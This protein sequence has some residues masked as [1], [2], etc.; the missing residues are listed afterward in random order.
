MS[1]V[2]LASTVLRAIH[3]AA[4]ASLFGTL[5]FTGVVLPPL[6]A[7]AYVP[8]LQ[9]RLAWLCRCSMILALV[10]GGAWLVTRAGAM[11][12]VEEVSALP[13]ALVLVALDTRFGRLLLLRLGL[14]FTVCLALR[15]PR[16]WVAIPL[17]GA[18]L[19]LQAATSHAGAMD[20]QPGQLLMLA[21]ALHI[22][23]AAAWLGALAPLLIVLASLPLEAAAAV[24][25]RFFPLGLA[26]VLAIA[27]TSLVQAVQLV[28]SVAALFGTAYGRMALLKL[29]L[30]GVLLVFAWL[31]RFVFRPGPAM[32]RSIS[33]EATVAA[34]LML[35][36]GSL[37]HMAPGGHEQA[38]WPFPWQLNPGGLSAPGGLFVAATPTTFFVSPTGFSAAA[39]VRGGRVYHAACAACHGA[40]GHGD[41]PAAGTLETVP[42][43]LTALRL[44][45]LSDGELFWRTGHAVSMTA[46][47]R[48]D[49][50]DYLRAHN[51]GEFVRTAGRRLQL[52]R[53]P[54]FGASCAGG[55]VLAEAD[56]RGRV[57]HLVVPDVVQP[58]QG[59]D[60]P[61]AATLV[62]ADAAMQAD[63]R[64][65]N[66]AP[67][68][69]P[70]LAILLGATPEALAG[71]QFLID[72]NGWLRA[73]WRPGE[74]AAWTSPE[75]LTAR[76]RML[77]ERPLPA[78][79]AD[80]HAGHH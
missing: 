15:R 64:A 13:G 56:L 61:L 62:L 3:L 10:A 28:G 20:G 48:W 46:D 1:G 8:R 24:I 39:I 63:G 18:A 80:A 53:I 2:D 35:A 32:R 47:D 19:A 79:P 57:L 38:V 68:A 31:N 52:L 55:R 17:S 69:R 5:V 71:Q 14:L 42:A 7:A 77:A 54:R 21:E 58:I 37:A 4:V 75:L 33:A 76:V 72:P 22:I 36:A 6:P 12:A 65:C 30:F 50:V 44:L 70:A 34:V 16:R 11:A 26:A 29:S 23:A 27:A 67:D 66:A 60:D 59:A 43:D 41:G 78:D 25:R 74:P 45:E 51:R 40:T 9:R 49:L 73:S